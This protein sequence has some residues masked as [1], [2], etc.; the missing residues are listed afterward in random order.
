MSNTKII[1]DE[2]VSRAITELPRHVRSGPTGIL[3]HAQKGFVRSPEG[4][5][6]ILLGLL[7]E[8][9]LPLEDGKLS[10]DSLVQNFFGGSYRI[11]GKYNGNDQ[12]RLNFGETNEVTSI[13]LQRIPIG[14]VIHYAAAVPEKNADHVC[15]YFCDYHSAPQDLSYHVRKLSSS[16]HVSALL[17]IMN[18]FAS[19]TTVN[20]ILHLMNPNR[21][22]G[23]SND[24]PIGLAVE[25]SKSTET[26]DAASEASRHEEDSKLSPPERAAADAQPPLDDGDFNI[27]GINDPIKRPSIPEAFPNRSA[28]VNA[29]RR[30]DSDFEVA[31]RS[32]TYLDQALYF[33]L[34]PHTAYWKV[35]D[36]IEEFSQSPDC[37]S[38]VKTGLQKI[39]G[40]RNRFGHDSMEQLPGGLKSQN[41]SKDG[42]LFV[43]NVV[44]SVLENI[45][46]HRD[47][48]QSL[49]ERIASLE[50]DNESL[51]EENENLR[52]NGGRGTPRQRDRGTPRQ[53]DLVSQF[54]TPRRPP[55]QPPSPHQWR[56]GA[57]DHS[58]RQNPYPPH[59]F[60]SPGR[61]DSS[62]NRFP[63]PHRGGFSPRP[64]EPRG[65]KRQHFN[66]SDEQCDKRRK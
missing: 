51:Q 17:L 62:G 55:N 19:A 8:D 46:E 54:H 22:S 40:W 24:S 60:G 47:D 49:Q 42:F 35:N 48:A 1:L 50:S 10:I 15:Q 64:S 16:D 63:S 65:R 29:L 45:Y 43:F 38:P 52:N 21:Q 11:G 2:F 7:R 53:R 30:V 56:E 28:T 59:N 37:K 41:M 13:Y 27:E 33:V 12:Y 6:K 18:K 66:N 31:I 34:G 5:Q 9:E 23:P 4:R 14:G 25:V 57:Q 61:R 26:T 20:A 58:G 44:A 32:G 3:I 36:K 39:C